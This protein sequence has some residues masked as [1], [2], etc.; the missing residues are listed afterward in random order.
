MENDDILCKVVAA[1]KEIRQMVD[2]EEARSREFIEKARKEAEEEV[3]RELEDMKVSL[4]AAV[5]KAR[6]H[7]E[8]RA[9]AIKASA[10]DKADRIGAISDERLRE[11]VLEHLASILPRPPARKAP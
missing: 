2:D 9:A 8:E 6:R 1:E 11:V 3:A 7:A 5:E 4:A 10:R